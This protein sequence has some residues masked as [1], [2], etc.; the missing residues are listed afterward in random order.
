MGSVEMRETRT[1]S[2]DL[3]LPQ[4]SPEPHNSH[5][6]SATV[7]CP[8]FLK[9]F[10]FTINCLASPLEVPIAFFQAVILATQGSYTSDIA[11]P[12]LKYLPW[13]AT[14][15]RIKF[16]CLNH[17]FHFFHYLYPEALL[18][19]HVLSF[20]SQGSPLMF[21]LPGSPPCIP[22]QIQSSL[23]IWGC[24]SPCPSL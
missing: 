22:C 16:K 10:C 24:S 15:P 7:S 5:K 13:L 2:G 19:K 11:P 17:T 12:Q 23:L 20:I 3:L 21:P 1:S 9:N 14:T 8:S 4:L 18:H 6:P